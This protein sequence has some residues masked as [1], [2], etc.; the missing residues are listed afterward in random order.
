MKQFI[1]NNLVL[2]M[3]IGGEVLAAGILLGFGLSVS[4]DVAEQQE[5]GLQAWRRA[6]NMP[7]VNSKMT[8]EQGKKNDFLETQKD[9]VDKL[10]AGM[11]RRYQ[12]LQARGTCGNVHPAFPKDSGTYE[13]CGGSYDKCGLYMPLT[14]KY[15]QRWGNSEGGWL[16]R[17]GS[18]QAPSENDPYLVVRILHW[19]RRLLDNEQQGLVYISKV[20]ANTI[21]ELKKKLKEIEP[22]AEQPPERI[23][24]PIWGEEPPLGERPIPERRR[25]GLVSPPAEPTTRA[26]ARQKLKSRIEGLRKL[27]ERKIEEL[28]SD[29]R[30][31]KEA[32]NQ[33]GQYR[34]EL[35]QADRTQR[36][37]LAKIIRQAEEDLANNARALTSDEDS[38]KKE[39]ATY[40]G[41]EQKE[42]PEIPTRRRRERIFVI[43]EPEEATEEEIDIDISEEHKNQ[44]KLYLERE[45]D[46]ADAE[47]YAWPEAIRYRAEAGKIYASLD[48]LDMLYAGGEWHVSLTELWK[49]QVN[50][51]VMEDILEAI[52]QTNNQV[53]SDFSSDR[54]D[55]MN[56]AVKHL[57]KIN[58]TEDYYG[59][60]AKESQEAS[61]LTGR[62]RGSRESGEPLLGKSLTRRISDEEYHVVRYNFS[63]V[64]PP[65]HVLRLQNNLMGD[66]LHTVLKVE[67]AKVDQ[68]TLS[69]P[70]GTDTEE[71]GVVT[72]ITDPSRYCYG[73][74]P[75]AL[76]TIYGE[77]LLRADWSDKYMPAGL[78]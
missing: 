50:L 65:R 73:T 3:L 7:P 57:V 11:S 38:L 58:I 2:V 21:G 29:V 26:T 72:G 47:S 39:I 24:L 76:M 12:I 19:R 60:R 63:V 78:K 13:K 52:E 27:Q 30:A 4:G 51:W 9:E 37:R 40:F 67:I 71:R 41:L 28:M 75:V 34:E 54:Q 36:R 14:D 49:M 46:L 56:A 35:A 33:I 31:L 66:K 44:A 18:T 70:P 15:A 32:V 8:E 23:P 48:A 5:A 61:A 22:E 74:E 17:L 55:V 64:M 6:A 69:K 25:P 68:E 59:W 43:A 10:L 77:L 53:L 62:R 45:V 16:R 20:I 42:Q 1:M